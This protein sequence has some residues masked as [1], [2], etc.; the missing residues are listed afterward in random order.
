MGE[1]PMAG[2]VVRADFGGLGSGCR[3]GGGVVGLMGLVGLVGVV[4]GLSW[5]DGGVAPGGK[6]GKMGPGA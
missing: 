6:W 4:G 5:A 2:V 3:I 1:A